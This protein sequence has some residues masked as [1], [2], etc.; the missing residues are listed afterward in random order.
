MS[1]RAYNKIKSSIW[2]SILGFFVLSACSPSHKDEVDKLNDTSYAFHYRSL[3][4]SESYARRA[5]ETSGDYDAGRSESLNNLAF[6]DIQRMEF[7]KARLKLDDVIRSSDNQIEQL[8][9]DIQ[10]MRICQRNSTNKDFYDY[11]ERAIRRLR[12]INEERGMLSP[13]DERRLLYAESE[14]HIVAAT[15]YYYVSLD[16]QSREA[17][18][19][20]NTDAIKSDTAQVLNYDYMIGSGGMLTG[21]NRKEQN[22]REFNYLLNCLDMADSKG[23]QYWVANSCQALAQMLSDSETRKQLFYEDPVARAYLNPYE[24]PDSAVAVT[25]AMDALNIFTNYGDIYQIAGSYR[26]LATCYMAQNN[27]PAAVTCLERALF[28]DTLINQA[29]ELVASIQEQMC[30]AYSALGMKSKSDNCRNVYLDLQEMTRQDRQLEARADAFDKQNVRMNIMILAIL[31][32][33][34]LLI[35]SLV[36]FNKKN[37]KLNDSYNL[38]K[39]LEPLDDWQRKNAQ[40]VEQRNERM[41]EISDAQNVSMM[42]IE[43]N[44]RRNEQQRAKIFL[45]NIITPLIDRIIYAAKKMKNSKEGSDNTET[46]NYIRELTENINQYNTVL[47]KWIQMRQGALSLKVESFQLKEL[48]DV[49]KKG[50]TAF[51]M[52]GVLLDVEDTDLTVKADRILTLFMI[53][54]LADNARKFTDA[55]G[56]VTIYANRFD[57]KFVEISVSDTGTGMSENELSAV[58]NHKIYNGHGFGLL[59]C[60][61]IIDKYRKTGTIFS[62]CMISAESK[63]GEGSRFYFR[64][65][66]G[67][68][69]TLMALLILLLP[70]TTYG[71]KRVTDSTALNAARRYADSSYYSNIARQYNRALAFADSSIYFFNTYYLQNYP[72]S[73]V[74]M[75]AMGSSTRLAP[76]IQ[77]FRSRVNT[78]YVKILRL[79][80]ESAVASLAL[81][82]WDLY[83]YNNRVYTKL[84]REISADKTL[85]AYCRTMQMKQTNQNI[86]VVLLILV[87]IMILPAYYMIYYRHRLYYRFCIERIGAINDLLRGDD[88]AE[89][90]LHEI[91]SLISAQTSLP[92]ELNGIST[93]VIKAL[94]DSIVNDKKQSYDIELAD[95]ELRRME[96][97]NNQLHVCNSVLDNSLS[98]LKHETMYYPSRIRQLADADTVDVNSICEVADYYR[99]IYTMLSSQLM[100]QTEYVKFTVE[101]VEIEGI[102]FFGDKVLLRYLFDILL[103]QLGGKLGEPSYSDDGC[104]TFSVSLSS[105]V[106]SAEQCSELF[107][108]SEENIPLLVCKQIVRDH[109]EFTNLRMCGISARPSTDNTGIIITIILPKAKIWK[110]SKSS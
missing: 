14:M 29:P 15:Y 1:F 82:K 33:I 93:R 32:A 72:D 67:V 11:H 36:I 50:K 94:K 108:P 47:T 48:F 80:N 69:R 30:V 52:K 68:R 76:E 104:V 89:D 105:L 55:G 101:N 27:Y 97:E 28:G 42:H 107:T 45:V 57:D 19:K 9:A 81:H 63:V 60:K 13:R 96:Y 106:L 100:R 4:R 40:Q 20:I 38:K 92:E 26:T 78:D 44:K 41:D 61:G 8:I 110:N 73:R 65:P 3:E 59:N 53:N 43:E 84:L 95:D 21:L 85:Q 51:A 16:R 83:N 18:F 58:F 87:L 31:G 7:A 74:L 49:V 34:V 98:T 6:V 5:Y 99:N 2:I 88:S 25:L 54:T 10:F 79:R 91:S 12:R 62:E 77:W 64:L 70:F 22:R 46:L 35:V 56:K 23:Y 37:N 103:K 90:K 17:L 102:Q 39:L 86:A 66:V 75:K 24:Q 109:S 71:A